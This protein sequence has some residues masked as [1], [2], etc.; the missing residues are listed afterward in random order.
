[1]FRSWFDEDA[2]AEM[3]RSA[4][5]VAN[6]DATE[7]CR[8]RLER[9]KKMLSACVMVVPVEQQQANEELWFSCAEEVKRVCD[10]FGLALKRAAAAKAGLVT[11]EDEGL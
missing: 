6:D 7:A 11:R 3:V 9:Q 2:W 1:M 5:C 8:L 10:T 4:V